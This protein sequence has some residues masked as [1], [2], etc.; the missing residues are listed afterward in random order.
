MIHSASDWMN[1]TG[2]GERRSVKLYFDDG[3]VASGRFSAL[4]AGFFTFNNELNAGPGAGNSSDTAWRRED[5][6]YCTVKR[7]ERDYFREYGADSP[8]RE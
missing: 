3:H 8:Y 1:A 2:T 7:I 4:E 5:Y 6:P